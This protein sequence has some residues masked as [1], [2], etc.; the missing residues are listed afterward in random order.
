MSA[1]LQGETWSF[2]LSVAGDA[3]IIITQ[4]RA[5]HSTAPLFPRA[6]FRAVAFCPLN[7]SAPNFYL[8]VLV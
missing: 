3:K 6:E 5:R 1:H 7:I 4:T 2:P 8:L